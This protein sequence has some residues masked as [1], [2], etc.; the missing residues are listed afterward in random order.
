MGRITPEMVAAGLRVLAD[1]VA[2]FSDEGLAVEE[3]Y[4]AMERAKPGRPVDPRWAGP[5]GAFDRK[6]YMREYMRKRRAKER[7]Q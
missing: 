7:G 1:Y 5:D 6:A 3:V 4:R 2:E